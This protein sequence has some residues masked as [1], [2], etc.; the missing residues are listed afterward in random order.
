MQQQQPLPATSLVRYDEPKLDIGD[1]AT[2]EDAIGA[3]LPPR[4]VEYNQR[5]DIAGVIFIFCICIITGDGLMRQE[6]SG[7]ST[8]ARNHVHD[9]MCWKP[10]QAWIRS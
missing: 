4:L 6:K 2:P 3:L 10:R 8:S 9:S 7:Y 1:L 5:C